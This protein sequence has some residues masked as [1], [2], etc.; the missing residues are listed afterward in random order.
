MAKRLALAL[1][2]RIGARR[3]IACW[4][5]CRAAMA[6]SDCSALGAARPA[7]DALAFDADFLQSIGQCRSA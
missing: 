2:L 5:T 7:Y 1:A 3:Y 4:V 6:V